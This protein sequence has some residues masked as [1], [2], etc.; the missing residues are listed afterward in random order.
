M[1][2]AEVI[3]KVVQRLE[4][5]FV[6]VKVEQAQGAAVVPYIRELLIRRRAQAI[7]AL[8]EHLARFGKAVPGGAANTYRLIAR[9]ENPGTILPEMACAA[10]GIQAR[11]C[12]R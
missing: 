9:I 7:D 2:D 8:R 3:S 12:P 5:R 10:L 6:S 1:A 4:T 11:R